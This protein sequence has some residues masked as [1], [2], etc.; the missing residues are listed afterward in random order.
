MN[1]VPIR[2]KMGVFEKRFLSRSVIHESPASSVQVMP[3]L[4]L[5]L[6]LFQLGSKG[7]G[8]VHNR[9]HR[10]LHGIVTMC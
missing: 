2:V 9:D 3:I 7:W 4:Q 1:V 6:I 10:Q 8:N 5:C